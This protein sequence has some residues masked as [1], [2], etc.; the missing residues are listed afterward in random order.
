MMRSAW[1]VLIS[2]LFIFIIG[3]ALS[4]PH[5]RYSESCELVINTGTSIVTFPM[6][7]LIQNTQKTPRL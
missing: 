3:W 7:F 1:A 5:F 2:V 6:V 4:G